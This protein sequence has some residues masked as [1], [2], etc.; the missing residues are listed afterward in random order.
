VIL[1]TS[2]VIGP[3][4][5]NFAL[6]MLRLHREREQIDV[7]ADQVGCPTSTATLAAAC[8]RVIAAMDTPA[9]LSAVL[10]WSD[11]GAA[12]WYDVAVAVGE[13]GLELGLLQTAAQVNPITTAEYSTTAQRP[14]YSLLECTASRQAL[15]LEP[16]HWRAAL[17][18]VIARLDPE[19]RPA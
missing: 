14:S 3:V 17:G 5:K 11:A 12:S 1:R 10:H 6:T 19:V 18:G 4:G 9:G 8:W 16:L 2:W 15:T 13:L 7:V